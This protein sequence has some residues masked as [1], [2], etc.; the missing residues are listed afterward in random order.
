VVMENVRNCGGLT[1]AQ[2]VDILRKHGTFVTL[3]EAEI[4]LSFMINLASFSLDE[5]LRNES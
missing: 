1:A 4:I 3:Q 2:V 5:I